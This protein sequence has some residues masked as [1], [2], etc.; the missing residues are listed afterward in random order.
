MNLTNQEDCIR[1]ASK[2]KP[3]SKFRYDCQAYIPELNSTIYNKLEDVVL[4]TK[5]AEPIVIIGPAKE[6]YTIP[7]NTLLKCYT[8]R[9]GTEMTLDLLENKGLFFTGKVFD[10]SW[11][12]NNKKVLYALKTNSDNVFTITTAWNNV[13][14]VNS[15]GVCHENGD[16]ILFGNKNNKPDIHD[17]WVVNGCV[18]KETYKFI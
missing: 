11:N 6:H 8:L 2:A 17:M 7:L 10:I 14:T 4:H 5:E 15:H 13:L 9:D 16:Y 12:D 1:N 3:V 18:F